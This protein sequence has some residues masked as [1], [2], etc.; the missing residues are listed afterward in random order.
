[1]LWAAKKCHYYVVD[2]LLKNGADPL[3][4]DDQGFNLLHSASLD[5]NVYQ[6][7]MLLHQ[8]I[9]V[10]V[11]DA[12]GHTSLMWAAYKGFPV[13]VDVLL[14]WGANVYARDA[15]GFTALHWALVKGNQHC[16][17]R[18]IEYGSDRFAET[19][20][21]KTPAKVAKE[22]NS[23]RQ[24][25]RALSDCNYNKDGSSRHFFLASIIKD[26]RIFFSRFFFLWPFFVVFVFL[27]L[28]SHLVIYLGLPLA[29]LVG[30][31]LQKGVQ[32][33]FRWAPPDM[34]TFP[35]TVS[36]RS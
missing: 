31:G 29:F 19:N 20:D 12:Q 25:H 3:L 18:L 17:F 13:V 33:L 22:M 16:I 28:I 23:V 26:R 27:F 9:P 10:D 1:M 34:K 14:A 15:Q 21:G 32:Y 6:I 7:A 11:P 4:T 5:G 2:L 30:F 35:K 8:D 36:Y 24:W